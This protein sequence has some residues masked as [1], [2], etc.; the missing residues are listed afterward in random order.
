MVSEAS[1]P[2]GTAATSFSNLTLLTF[3]IISRINIYQHAS[4]SN[5]VTLP[6]TGFPI[7]F[8]TLM[9]TSTLADNRHFLSD[10]L[11][12]ALIGISSAM[13]IY[14]QYFPPVWRK[15]AVYSL[16]S[17]ETVEQDLTLAY[18]P[19]RFFDQNSIAW[20][21]DPKEIKSSK[22]IVESSI[23]ETSSESRYP[24]YSHITV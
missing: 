2:S 15:P 4:A 7:L 13:L 22:L 12:G 11:V 24:L 3:M 8:A 5:S 16:A 14:R 20:Q 6:I 18:E 21:I 17:G 9:S 10:N 19:K 23:R 1:F